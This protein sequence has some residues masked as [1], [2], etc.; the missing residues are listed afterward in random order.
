[1]NS[2]LVLPGQRPAMESRLK[3]TVNHVTGKQTLEVK[4]TPLTFVMVASVLSHQLTFVLSELVK[5]SM[6]II[7]GKETPKVDEPVPEKEVVV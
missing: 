2:P 5:Q 3:I 6:G 1:M 7:Q 4:G